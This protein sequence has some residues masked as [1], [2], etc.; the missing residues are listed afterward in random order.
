MTRRR[1]RM[2]ESA[3]TIQVPATTT[4]AR[5]LEKRYLRL[6]ARHALRLWQEVPRVRACLGDLDFAGGLYELLQPHLNGGERQSLDRALA[7]GRRGSVAEPD[8]LCDEDFELLCSDDDE[9]WLEVL[10]AIGVRLVLDKLQIRNFYLWLERKMPS[11]LPRLDQLL[12]V[13]ALR[14]LLNEVRCRS[15]HQAGL[16]GRMLAQPEN[17]IRRKPAA[18]SGLVRARESFD[19]RSCAAGAAAQ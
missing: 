9:E 6:A 16:L 18:G 17:R 10:P 3:R 1:S 5:A 7:C 14:R 4:R 12:A 19:C 15:R 13:P 2:I 8:A 11:L